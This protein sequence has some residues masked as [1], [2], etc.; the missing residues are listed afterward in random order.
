M[1]FQEDNSPTQLSVTLVRKSLVSKDAQPLI[2]GD[3]QQ[4]D[5]SHVGNRY[6]LQLVRS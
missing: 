6:Q 5:Q 1:I 3:R 4:E 2:E